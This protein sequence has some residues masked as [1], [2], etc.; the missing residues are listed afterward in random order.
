MDALIKISSSEFNEE[1]FKKIK[2][3]IG[4][5]GNS[6]VTIAVR[7]SSTTLRKETKEQYWD[8]LKTAAADLENGKGTVFTMDELEAF[9]R[10]K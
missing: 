10:G 3:L 6:E 1:V 4:S 2:E 5:F 9:M 7:S 8:R